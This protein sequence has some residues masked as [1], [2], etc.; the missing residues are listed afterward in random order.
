[1]K[2]K[3]KTVI[4]KKSAGFFGGVK[5]LPISKVK[6]TTETDQRELYKYILKYEAIYEVFE[7]EEAFFQF[8]KIERRSNPMEFI[9]EC[10]K[11]PKY[12]KDEKKL[13][14]LKKLVNTFIFPNS[15]KE[16]NISQQ[17]RTKFI[18]KLT[19]A[20]QLE[21][22][23]W[24]EKPIWKMKN[25]PLEEIFKEIK[26]EVL[27]LLKVQ[28]YTKFMECPLWKHIEND[29][30]HNEQ[31]CV[32]MRIFDV[33]EQESSDKKWKRKNE[34]DE[35]KDKKKLFH[36]MSKEARK[37][38]VESQSIPEANNTDDRKSLNFLQK[39]SD[40]GTYIKDSP[41]KLSDVRN[42]FRSNSFLRTNS[43]NNLAPLEK[44]SSRIGQFIKEKLTGR[45]STM[46]EVD[47]SSDS[48]G[49]IEVIDIPTVKKDSIYFLI[50]NQSLLY[51]HQ[52]GIFTE[53][54]FRKSGSDKSINHFIRKCQKIFKS[55]KITKK[56][57]IDFTAE[58]ELIKDVHNIAGLV[59]TSLQD[60]SEPLITY[61]LY[62]NFLEVDDIKQEKEKIERL[63]IIFF[64]FL[65][66]ENRESFDLLL[67]LL[68]QIT[69]NHSMTLMDPENLSIVF[70]PIIFKSE[71]TS[72]NA[73]LFMEHLPVCQKIMKT[74]ISCFKDIFEKN[75]LNTDPNV[76]DTSS[77]QQILEAKKLKQERMKQ[78]EEQNKKLKQEKEKL[79][80]ER[81]L[82]DEK[83]KKIE[84]EKKKRESA[85][86]NSASDSETKKLNRKSQKTADDSATDS[87]DS[88]GK[89]KMKIVKKPIKQQQLDD[90]E[91][92]LEKKYSSL[93]LPPPPEDH[94]E[95]DDVQ[96]SPLKKSN[97]DDSDSD[98]EYLPTEENDLEKKFSI[99]SLP[100]PPPDEEEEEEPM[101]HNEPVIPIIVEKEEQSHQPIIVPSKIRIDTSSNEELP[102]EKSVVEMKIETSDENIKKESMKE[103]PVIKSDSSTDSEDEKKTNKSVVQ[104]KVD[105]SSDSEDDKPKSIK[106]SI[107]KAD[108]SST[109]SE[110]EKP[111]VKIMKK[112]IQKKDDT[113]SEDEKPKKSPIKKKPI[114]KADSSSTDSEDEKPKV[115]IMKKPIQKKDDT[116]SED[117]KPK[118]LVK[119]PVKK[120]ID[121]SSED[122][123]PKMI[124][125]PIKKADSSSTDSE[126]EKPKRIP[127]KK[128]P[129][130]K[131][132]SSSSEDE[133]PKKKLISKRRKDSSSSEEE[134][135]KSTI[136]DEKTDKLI[137]EA[138]LKE[139][140]KLLMDEEY[141]EEIEH[142][143]DFEK[144]S[145]YLAEGIEF[146]KQKKW[147]EAVDKFSSAIDFNENLKEA[148]FNRG[149]LNYNAE[150][151]LNAVMDM[152]KVIS[153]DPNMNKAY[154]VRALSLK[155][156]GKYE[157]AIEDFLKSFEKDNIVNNFMSIGVCYDKVNKP[158]EAINAYTK[159]IKET[160]K[161]EEEEM[162][163]IT[164][165]NLIFVYC[166]RGL[167]FCQ[168][169]KFSESLDDYTNAIKLCKDEDQI[170]E[171]KALR[172]KSHKLFGNEEKAK[173]DLK[174]SLSD[175]EHYN[176][177]LELVQKK[178]YEKAHEC[179]S[180]AIE[181]N[182]ENLN[183]YFARSVCSK[184][185]K[186]N[187][188]AIEDL[189]IAMKID[190]EV[191]KVLQSLGKLYREKGKLSNALKIFGK[192]IEVSPSSNAYFFRADILSEVDGKEEEAL[193]DYTNAIKLDKNMFK[194]YYN[195]GLIYFHSKR[196]EK[197]IHDFDKAIEI[198]E[199][200]NCYVDRGLSYYNLKDVDTAVKDF[201]KA[202][203]LGDQR[204]KAI[205]RDLKIE[206]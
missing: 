204:G 115:K 166:N 86:S 129:I 90:D 82:Q 88:D 45:E 63:K 94:K 95:I 46:R 91:S 74:I 160:E 32:K 122:D 188:E 120:P 117:E 48:D 170:R 190:S 61:D 119:K 70:T 33:V 182:S 179:F 202:S 181:M 183:Y 2:K 41:R 118:K 200:S 15:E 154:S 58:I 5:P 87:D 25:E 151:H 36:F 128:K 92:E 1:M 130:K 57:K 172:S 127:I 144:A 155:K 141:D 20:G 39:I 53:G 191:P 71:E 101:E 99:M 51:L 24:D 176:N 114:K 28:E 116:S 184:N 67:S 30:H 106:K 158:D 111:K 3:S 140:K 54:I 124:K 173:E 47:S 110:D 136:V 112:P 89:P 126:D 34:Q 42:S 168:R 159:F 135:V 69:S 165:K 196:Y 145:K 137:E 37:K 84:V 27:Q 73:S 171:I 96:K 75:Y 102:I 105:T 72:K 148:Y 55:V 60:L 199:D 142:E 97:R 152:Y 156:L 79:E 8:L 7:I 197:A 103:K 4:E 186:K 157:L 12:Q 80:L 169:N 193:M 29:Y 14:I 52:N 194:A 185:L 35:K 22:K 31:V 76:I 59:I 19:S 9:R 64:D 201:K 98:L 178:D 13:F 195:R 189:L 17:T 107:K 109:D 108:S 131:Y 77:L 132:S 62:K 143:Q 134:D 203:K 198:D 66:K 100:P 177:G 161:E 138:R 146:V 16:L 167:D 6:N 125:K 44:R 11:F 149:L 26:L 180:N 85:K 18:L 205:L 163:S 133:K 164:R 68:H 150:R 121:T 147:E 65:P 187:D 81:K 50:M 21:T 78:E 206:L 123:K 162:S 174:Q 40:L 139:Q 153:I 113:S 38:K 175:I 192:L 104:K 49:E 56:S 10:E 93:S 23:N 43:S 83:E